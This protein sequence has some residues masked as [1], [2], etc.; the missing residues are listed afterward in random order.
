[1]KRPRKS[2]PRYRWAAPSRGTPSTKAAN[3]TRVGRSMAEF[4]ECVDLTR[5]FLYTLA[6]ESRPRAVKIGA[7]VVVV[8]EPLAW[9]LRVGRPTYRRSPDQISAAAHHQDSQERDR[10]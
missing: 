10:R 8:E 7:R 4:A 3:P 9:L 6:P 5:Q 1:M 2:N